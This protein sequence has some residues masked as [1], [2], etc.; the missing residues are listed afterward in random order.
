MLRSGQILQLI[1]LAL[2]GLAVVMVQSAAM[3]VG[4]GPM[5]PVS[6]L[7]NRTSIYALLAAGAMF[8]A[9]QM[10]VRR[11]THRHGWTNPLFWLLG[12]SMVLVVAAMIPGVGVTIN[13]AK[14]WLRL[15]P[16]SLGLTFQPSELVKWAILLALALWCVRRG[17]LMR[18]FKEGLL[19]AILILGLACGLIVIQ[20]LGTS[21]LIAMV[22]TVL[23][24]AAGAR[25][26]HLALLIPPAAVALIFAIAHSPYRRARL[27][28]FLDPFADPQKTGYQAI[29]SLVAIAQ[30][31]LTGK[32]LGNGVQKFD[33]LPA[34]T[35]DFI[36]ATI[37]E[38]LG[39]AGAVLVVL[40]Y[41]LLLYA[42]LRIV[43]SARDPFAKLVALGVTLTI[44]MQALINIAV[45]TVVVPTKGIALPLLSSGG[46]GWIM[47]AF[48]VGLVAA[49][50]RVDQSQEQASLL[51]AWTESDVAK[52]TADLPGSAQTVVGA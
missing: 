5:D 4:Q 49:M 31:S 14:R 29:Q 16:P 32:G 25:F 13:G 18:L 27:T 20:D 7:V 21:A 17:A 6:I 26:W 22:A 43:K 19:P 40:L 38:E 23:L 9:S 46:T 51:P 41:V 52:P 37:C 30:G 11:L 10:D 3:T 50:D 8:L 2:L 35:T 36:Y 34:D 12:F 44:G 48:M 28:S 47:T 42:G 15:G 1:V 33:Y 45:V 24:I 39:L